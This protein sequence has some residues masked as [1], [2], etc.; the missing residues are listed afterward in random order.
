LNSAAHRRAAIPDDFQQDPR[1]RAGIHLAEPGWQMAE[2]LP[3]AATALGAGAVYVPP[4][5]HA[6]VVVA[7]GSDAR[8]VVVREA[9]RH[10]RFGTVY[11]DLERVGAGRTAATTVRLIADQFLSTARWI[12]ERPE[13][14]GLPVGIFGSDI[15]GG[16]ALAAAAARP[17][18]FRAL[19][20]R[21]S[22]QHL[23]GSVVSVV[24]AA[25]LLIVNG[26]D[27]AAVAMNQETMTRVRGIAELEILPGST[28]SD[29]PE[30]FAQVAQLTRRWFGRFLA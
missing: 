10:A 19:V 15:A 11:V 14:A 7:H 3:L 1:V 16:A 8:D 5:A 9:L 23:A 27:D 30:S 25:T 4:D 26:D 28:A 2:T 29:D 24:Q 22:R 13:F 20:I 6:I 17:D 12:G 18:I 21:D